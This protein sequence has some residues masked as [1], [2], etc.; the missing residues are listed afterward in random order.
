[1]T[2]DFP[3]DLESISNAQLYLL[4]RDMHT[5]LTSVTEQLTA[6]EREQRDMLE[7]WK[8]GKTVLRIIKLA[9]SVGLAIGAL[10]AMFK[11]ASQ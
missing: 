5:K 6:L 3:R 4:L 9:G 1:M 8:A 10:I 7:T 2:P 11:G